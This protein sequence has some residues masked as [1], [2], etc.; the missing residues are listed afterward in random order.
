MLSPDT[1]AFLRVRA[2]I[3]V[4]FFDLDG[5]LIDTDDAFLDSW[6][7]RLARLSWLFPGGDPRPLLRRA[8][9]AAEGPGNA[10]VTLLDALGLDDGLFAIG[11]RLGQV[12]GLR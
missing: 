10:F 11:D 4:I 1:P 5:T 2:R 12:R 3:E 8:M 9:L 6:S 7:A